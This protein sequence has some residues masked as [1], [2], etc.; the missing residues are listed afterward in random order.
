MSIVESDG[1]PS[2]SLD[3]SETGE[4]T[5]CPWVGV[6]EGTTGEKNRETVTASLCLVF[7]GCGRVLAPPQIK[8]INNF[9]SWRKHLW[10][11]LRV[12]SR[13]FKIQGLQVNVHCSRNR[14]NAVTKLRRMNSWQKNS[15]LTPKMSAKA[16]SCDDTQD[17]CVRDVALL[18]SL[19]TRR[20]WQH[21]RQR[22]RVRLDRGPRSW[23]E[24]G[25][26]SSRRF[27]DTDFYPCWHIFAKR[28]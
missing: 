5:K 15:S 3:A 8:S 14:L 12:A 7:N 10:Y 23:R 6:V 17:A 1:P 22:S 11:Q 24:I 21:E 18:E 2:W 9:L 25:R 19:S 27:W 26:L 16:A 4:S 28:C 20:S 13:H